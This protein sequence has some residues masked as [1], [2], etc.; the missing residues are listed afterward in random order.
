MF[1][2]GITPKQIVNLQVII[3][4]AIYQ[5][6]PCTHIPD[7]HDHTQ[8]DAQ[9]VGR[10]HFVAAMTICFYAAHIGQYSS[11]KKMSMAHGHSKI[12]SPLPSYNVISVQ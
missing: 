2:T 4:T 12:I 9:I 11:C 10:A 6:G 1:F 5:Q 7:E 3:A 8:T